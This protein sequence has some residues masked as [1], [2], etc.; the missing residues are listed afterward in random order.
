MGRHLSEGVECSSA[1]CFLLWKLWGFVFFFR[2]K[3]TRSI[4]DRFIDFILFLYVGHQ[5]VEDVD[6]FDGVLRTPTAHRSTL[7][8]G[9]LLWVLSCGTTPQQPHRTRQAHGTSITDQF[10]PEHHHPHGSNSTTHTQNTHRAPITPKM[11]AL[12][13]RTA[14]PALRAASAATHP[15]NL[16]ARAF[17][18]RAGK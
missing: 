11:L 7:R 4:R 15:T 12:S 10:D 6:S 1:A 17:S 5:I 3:L 18:S 13:R 2:S 16:A 14:A 9:N 8:F